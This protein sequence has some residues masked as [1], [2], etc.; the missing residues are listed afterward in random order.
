M[1]QMNCVLRSASGC[2]T[3]QDVDGRLHP[4]ALSVLSSHGCMYVFIRPETQK[5]TNYILLSITASAYESLHYP[6]M[7]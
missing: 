6:V 2:A 3:I 1:F 4:R 5:Q 7:F